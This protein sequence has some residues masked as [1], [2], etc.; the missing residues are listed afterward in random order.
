MG[1]IMAWAAAGTVCLGLLVA[2]SATLERA[3]WKR[4]SCR[5][6]EVKVGGV[7]RRVATICSRPM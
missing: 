7:F 5:V 2:I 1:R 3:S 4:E 6:Y